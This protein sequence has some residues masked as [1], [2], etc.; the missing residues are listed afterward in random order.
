MASKAV[1]DAVDAYLG[2]HWAHV[3][4]CP[5]FVENQQG[6]IPAD[7]SAFLKLQ[8]PAANVDR[9]SVTDRLY[10]EQGAVRVLIHVPRGAGTALIRQYGSEVA[11][12]FRDQAFS[13]VRCLVPTEPFTDD[14]SDQGLYFVGSVVV[15]YEFYFRE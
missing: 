14:E 4:V 8:Y 15:P 9:L 6:E 11:A 12:L 13:G 5:I 1:E 3:D 7:G 10:R 2:A